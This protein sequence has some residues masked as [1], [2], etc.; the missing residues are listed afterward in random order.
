MH[1]NGRM[2]IVGVAN[3]NIM[4]QFSEGYQITFQKNLLAIQKNFIF[5]KISRV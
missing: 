3:G 4:R 5:A 2:T 1:H